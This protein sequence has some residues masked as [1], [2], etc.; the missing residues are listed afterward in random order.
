[1]KLLLKLLVIILLAF[2]S[3]TQQKSPNAKFWFFETKLGYF[4]KVFQ[5]YRNSRNFGLEIYPKE[6]YVV[7]KFVNISVE[8]EKS[9]EVR[10][11]LEAEKDP[12]YFRKCVCK[13][14]FCLHLFC[15]F[16][17][18]LRGNSAWTQKFAGILR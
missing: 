18:V 1:M 11:C 12:R 6:K 17:K 13:I 14:F 4:S 7:D 2:T 9:E 5:N 8:K 15:D 10:Y 3:T 16:D